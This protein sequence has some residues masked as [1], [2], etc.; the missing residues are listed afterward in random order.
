MNHLKR[1]LLNDVDELSNMEGHNAWR[2]AESRAL[3]DLVQK[4][5]HYLQNPSDCS[6]ARKLLCNI[7]KV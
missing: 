4:R 5:L 1:V 7:N 2:A 6:K 3:S